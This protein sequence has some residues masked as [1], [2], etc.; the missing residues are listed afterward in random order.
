MYFSNTTFSDS[1]TEKRVRKAASAANLTGMTGS[2]TLAKIG[3]ARSRRCGPVMPLRFRLTVRITTRA[4]RRESTGIP[5]CIAA[6]RLSRTDLLAS[7][8]ELISSA[9]KYFPAAKMEFSSMNV[10]LLPIPW[11]IMAGVSC[12]NASVNE[13]GDSN[14]TEL[15]FNTEALLI[16]DVSTRCF[17]KLV[18]LP[19]GRL[20]IKAPNNRA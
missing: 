16:L 1:T 10:F 20:F 11:Q 2:R 19:T 6:A 12:G 15:R 7:R 17:I 8:L 9:S 13:V 4:K 5:D 18:A 14:S 3:G